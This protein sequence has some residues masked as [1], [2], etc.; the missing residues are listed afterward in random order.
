MKLT[1]YQKMIIKQELFEILDNRLAWMGRDLDLIIH[2]YPPEVVEDR[3]DAI[4]QIKELKKIMGEFV[5]G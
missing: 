4:N 1:D 2:S 3:I 5:D